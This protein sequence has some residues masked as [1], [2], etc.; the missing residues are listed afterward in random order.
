MPNT[1]PRCS[2]TN[3]GVAR[4]CRN[5][6]LALQAADGGPPRAGLTPHPQ[7]LTPPPDFNPIGAAVDLH[8]SWSAA[9]GGHTL[10]GTEPL[11]LNLFNGGYDLAE[12][13]LAVRGEDETGGSLF[14]IDR[15][16]ET[17][18]RGSVIQVEIPSYELP[19]PVKTLHV[20]LISAAFG[21]QETG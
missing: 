6:G 3:P 8:F 7:A 20:A 14:A 12:V 4:Y 9:G 16:V 5:C 18:P 15:E 13:V 17:W 10:L 1:C 21:Q 19:D 11:E 2:V